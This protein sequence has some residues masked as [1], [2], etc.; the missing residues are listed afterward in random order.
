MMEH[1]IPIMEDVVL[2]EIQGLPDACE[3]VIEELVICADRLRLV[4]TISD[5]VRQDPTEEF[6]PAKY[7]MLIK[8]KMD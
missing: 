1:P 8:Y 6:D 2:I 5:M 7:A 4:S 3:A